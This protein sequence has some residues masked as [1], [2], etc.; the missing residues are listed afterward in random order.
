MVRD[1]SDG[2]CICLT[3]LILRHTHIYTLVLLKLNHFT[4][5]YFYYLACVLIYVL[6]LCRLKN[7]GR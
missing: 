6:F 7:I 1:V 2:C 3:E 5:Q 4:A